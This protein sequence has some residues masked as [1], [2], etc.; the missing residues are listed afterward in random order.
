MD[1]RQT[2]FAA[3]LRQHLDWVYSTARRRVRDAALADDVA[4]A[5]FLLLWRKL[6]HLPP[7]HRLTGW[8]YRTVQ[9]CASNAVRLQQIRQKH[10]REAAMSRTQTTPTD[11]PWNDLA[12]HLEPAMD[13]LNP[14]D[15]TALL[16]RFYRSQSVAEVAST[17][18]ITE[19]AAKKRLQ[20]AL[21]RLRHALASQQRGLTTTSAAL[22]ATLL[23]H[24][25]TPA[26]ASLSTTILTTIATPAAT[27][28]ATVASGVSQTIL[29][30]KVK[31]AAVA[32][33][34]IGLT[35]GIVLAQRDTTPSIAPQPATAP[36]SAPT[37]FPRLPADLRPVHEQLDVP[38][39]IREARDKEAWIDTVQTFRATLQWTTTR[40][41]EQIKQRTA[42]LLKQNPRADLSLDRN[43]DLRPSFTTLIDIA[44][45]QRRYSTQRT[46]LEGG[47]W[48]KETWDGQT[49]LRE[50]QTATTTD[51]KPQNLRLLLLSLSC[52]RTANHPG[53]FA[54]AEELPEDFFGRPEDFH[55]AG[56][57]TYHGTDCYLLVCPASYRRWYIGVADHRIYGVTV[58]SNT[59]A[60]LDEH[61]RIMRQ[62]YI[63]RAGRAMTDQELG[64]WVEKLPA[65][66]QVEFIREGM[67]RTYH[68]TVPFA[69][70]WVRDYKE[71]APGL[72]FPMT[73]GVS[74]HDN[75][76][77]A[78]AHSREGTITSIEINQPLPDDLW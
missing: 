48:T 30:T 2:Q 44:F 34:A 63:E 60:T 58:E 67:R 68:L 9:Y 42:E 8:L 14:A 5:A 66:Q 33:F 62:V 38:A 57:T 75:V 7:D 54:P 29:W 4:Q 15:R 41:P 65:E 37:A 71:I 72:F 61:Q 22:G 27:S 36:T 13:C 46:E 73:H 6:P 1:D 35:A 78:E 20:R 39:L 52:F 32:L 21:D 10:E 43:L 19:E 47:T 25:T 11:L 70:N 26:P 50:T 45:D 23:A 16:L 59:P 3:L 76:G 64:A 69:E 55:L 12:D 18:G 51:G 53:R 49:F 24:S 56:R 31:V 17:L 74:I 28:A 77:A 40:T